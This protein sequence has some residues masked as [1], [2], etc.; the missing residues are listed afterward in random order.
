VDIRE[1]RARSILTRTGGFLRQGFS[2]TL[3]PYSGCAYGRAL[4]GGPCY[5][6]HSSW[7]SR[8]RGWGTFLEAK[9]N[10]AE[11]YRGQ[12]ERE[13]RWAAA[14]GGLRFYMSSVTDPYVPQERS[15]RITRS[16]LEAMLD[17]PPDRLAI[18]TH[19]PH[20]LWDIALLADLRRRVPDLCVNISVETDRE[21]M[22]PGFPA[23]ATPIAERI[24]A[25]AGL[26]RAGIPCVAVVAPILPIDDAGEFAR[27][28]GEA[29][30]AV[31]L[32]HFLIGDGSPGGLRTRRTGFPDRLAAAGWPDWTTLARFEQVCDTFRRVL[33]PS[34]V[35]VSC[36][37]FN[38]P[39]PGA[40]LPEPTARGGEDA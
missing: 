14:R 24:A 27:R 21:R 12:F 34:R 22:G 29:A 13:R 23:H 16:L 32:D 25:L 5:A 10:A 4:C 2:H 6:Q 8:G 37:G 33:G 3:N 35:G 7:I 15:Y 11:V 1:V 20:P 36:V 28:L 19:T 9:V 38:A 18:Q 30:D 17:F 39:G 31:V 26:R 40:R